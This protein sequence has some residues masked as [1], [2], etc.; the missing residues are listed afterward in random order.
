MSE[1]VRWSV[2]VGVCFAIFAVVFVSACAHGPES[3]VSPGGRLDVVNGLPEPIEVFVSGGRVALLEPGATAYLDR[4]PRREVT[5]DVVAV[6][7]ANEYRRRVDLAVDDPVRWHVQATQAQQDEQTT[8]K[9]GALILDNRSQE[10]VRPYLNG[11]AF[12]LV[13]PDARVAFSGLNVGRIAVEVVGVK[14]EFRV[15]TDMDLA[16]GTTGVFVVE[17]PAAALRVINGAD[18]TVLVHL[19]RDGDEVTRLLEPGAAWVVRGLVAGE[20]LHLRGDDALKRPFWRG[21][22]T[23][24]TGR[25]V[26]VTV[27]SPSGVLAVVSEFDE[28]ATILIDGRL[29]GVVPPQGASEFE[30]LVPG[31]VRVQAFSADGTVLARS[32]ISVEPGAKPLWF[33]R[34]GST[35]E[36]DEDEGALLVVNATDESLGI[37]IDGWERG[38]IEPDQRRRFEGLLPGIHAVAAAGTRSQDVFRMQAEVVKGAQLTWTVL[39]RNA[40]LSLNNLR[41]EA[42]RVLVDEEPRVEV[43]AGVTLEVDVPSGKRM[44]EAVGVRTLASTRYRMDLPAATVTHLDLARPLASVRVTNRQSGPVEVSSEQGVLGFVGPGEA[45]VFDSLLPGH[46]RLRARSVDLPVTWNVLAWL[47]AGV[48]HDWSLGAPGSP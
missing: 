16:S 41:D 44:I 47:V 38:R 11:R 3:L 39:P 17:P 2:P 48:V 24:E 27:P 43:E 15:S 18:L 6:A 12:E 28:P 1:R 23:P 34:P 46:H 37:Q 4:L 45:V 33:L 40:T 9:T 20:S 10:P 25:V 8:R 22:V 7:S 36:L 5:V 21:T 19:S 32:R 31:K 29:L 30:G 42:V 26:E 13:Y 35:K 14:T